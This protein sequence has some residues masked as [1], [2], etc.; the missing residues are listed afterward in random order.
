MVFKL[1]DLGLYRESE[2]I[3][4]DKKLSIQDLNETDFSK[5]NLENSLFFSANITQKDNLTSFKNELIS[6]LPNYFSD[7][8]EYNFI[9]DKFKSSEARQFGVGFILNYSLFSKSKYFE[10]LVLDDILNNYQ[11]FAEYKFEVSNKV[12]YHLDFKVY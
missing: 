7:I 1:D 6:S 3:L 2:N 12:G 8:N 10:N 4:L 9:I 11:V 5:L